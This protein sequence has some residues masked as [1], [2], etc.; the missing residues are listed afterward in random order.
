[1]NSKMA[2]YLD[3]RE[4]ATLGL[5]TKAKD[6]KKSHGVTKKVNKTSDF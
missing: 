1:M 3:G 4:I 5:H 6:C 2:E